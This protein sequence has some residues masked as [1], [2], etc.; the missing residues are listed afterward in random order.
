MSNGLPRKAI[1]GLE[2]SA[3]INVYN[4][5]TKEIVFC[6]DCKQVSNFLGV[7]TWAVHQYVISKNR[8]RK[9]YALRLKKEN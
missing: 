4:I 8:F 3:N 6:G 1:T 9:M 5:F 2:G 7:N